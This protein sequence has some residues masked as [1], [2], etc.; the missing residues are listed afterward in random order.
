MPRYSNKRKKQS[1]EKTQQGLDEIDGTAEQFAKGDF[2]ILAAICKLN[3]QMF[4]K[5][6]GGDA[7]D[8]LRNLRLANMCI[9]FD[10]PLK[11]VVYLK[12]VLDHKRAELLGENASPMEGILVDFLITDIAALYEVNFDIQRASDRGD[13][14]ATLT[15]LE[16]RRDTL[17]R[18]LCRN[19]KCLLDV[20]EKLRAAH[21]YANRNDLAP[22]LRTTML[23]AS[24]RN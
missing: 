4:V 17:N 23:P 16:H 19:M 8:R 1:R 9:S 5:R 2:A 3:P 14:N 10:N 12:T 22:W 15:M 7:L 11:E 13:D 20:R 18:L 24:S 6:F 21:D